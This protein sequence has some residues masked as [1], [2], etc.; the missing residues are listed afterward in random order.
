M[1][2]TGLSYGAEI[3]MYAEWNSKAFRAV[4]AASGS[5]EPM[6]YVLGGLHFAEF[7]D[8]RGFAAP[9][10]TSFA[11]WK[12][13]SLGLNARPDLPPLLLQSSDGEEYFGTPET[14]FRL[15]RAGAAVEWYE[16]PDE[17]HV[18]RS[19]ST[20]WWVYERNLEWFLFWLKDEEL[21]NASR[22][23]QYVRWREM[24]ERTRS[25]RR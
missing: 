1:G 21:S 2:L 11:L 8:S 12:E 5:W 4:S 16:Y 20:K 6:N 3:A 13:L 15:R 17:G 24:R 25:L 19:P 22:L 23:D 18:K 7:L 9:G 10:E 14:W